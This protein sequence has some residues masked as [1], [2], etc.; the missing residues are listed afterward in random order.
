MAFPKGGERDVWS[1]M[2]VEPSI[3]GLCYFQKTGDDGRFSYGLVIGRIMHT[4]PP[5]VH[6]LISRN[7]DYIR[8]H[9]KRDSVDV[10]K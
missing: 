8:L 9:D 1:K 10:I 2:V 4:P 7:C 5:D 3:R 6:I